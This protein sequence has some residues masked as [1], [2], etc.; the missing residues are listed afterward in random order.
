M[1]N[2]IV[3]FR[4]V[5][6]DYFSTKTLQTNCSCPSVL[7]RGFFFLKKGRYKK[8]TSQQIHEV[9]KRQSFRHNRR[10][11]WHWGC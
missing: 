11:G 3:F 2:G 1:V 9:F 4:V 7:R 8:K 6:I 5:A 10:Y